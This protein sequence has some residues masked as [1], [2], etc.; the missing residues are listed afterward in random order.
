V[1]VVRWAYLL[2]VALLGAL[3]T[4]AWTTSNELADLL[5]GQPDAKDIDTVGWL[6]FSGLAL[7]SAGGSVALTD[8]SVVVRVAR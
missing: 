2:G 8:R 4:S 5:R 7:V 6:A 1:R 3:F